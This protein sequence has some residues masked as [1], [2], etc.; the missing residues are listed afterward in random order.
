MAGRIEIRVGALCALLRE[1]GLGEPHITLRDRDTLVWVDPASRQEMSRQARQ[2]CIDAGLI[3]ES[4]VDDETT[5]WLATLTS[6][7][8][9]YYAWVT[10][11]GQAMTILVAAI[12]RAAALAVRCGD[13]VHLARITARNLGQALIAALPRTPPGRGSVNVRLTDLT[14]AA[15]ARDGGN[16]SNLAPRDPEVDRYAEFARMPA[17][18]LGE[19]HVAVRDRMGRRR[20]LSKPL[21]YRDTSEGRWLVQVDSRW[22]SVLPGDDSLIATRLAGA[23]GGLS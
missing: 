23:R 2:E 7:S 3:G 15:E 6:P 8:V 16:D 12:G 1:L 5:G 9:E 14:D 20:A 22:M 4:D 21:R 11:S 10:D 13:T 18:G 19:F 17:T